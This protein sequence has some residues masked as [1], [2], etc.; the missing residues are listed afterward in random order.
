MLTKD[1]E[2]IIMLLNHFNKNNND[3]TIIKNILKSVKNQGIYDDVE[4]EDICVNIILFN[5]ALI[6]YCFILD[7]D[8]DCLSVLVTDLNGLEKI[9]IINKEYILQV[10]VVYADDILITEEESEG[11]D[12]K[13]VV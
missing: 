12:D 10:N 3:K 2:R 7:E 9:S 6:P 4:I 13:M 5:E 11:V 1:I 8:K